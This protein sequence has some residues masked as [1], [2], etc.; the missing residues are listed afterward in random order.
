MPRSRARARPLPWAGAPRVCPRP[1]R[2]VA[3]PPPAV[4]PFRR[5][6]G[7]R[8]AWAR[9]RRRSRP[10]AAPVAAAACGEATVRR[11]RERRVCVTIRLPSPTADRR[12]VACARAAQE[13]ATAKEATGALQALPAAPLPG[14][15]PALLAPG[16]GVWGAPPP[17]TRARPP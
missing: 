10:P 1:Y 2:D 6:S 9:R 4:G 13:E 16:G 11:A 17:A 5:D 15:A 14:P 8:A 7:R 3:A 12:C